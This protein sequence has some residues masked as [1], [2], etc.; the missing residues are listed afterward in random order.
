MK[1]AS[2]RHR[3]ASNP[4]VYNRISHQANYARLKMTRKEEHNSSREGLLRTHSLPLRPSLEDAYR[5]SVDSDDRL[6]SLDLNAEE[7]A[8]LTRRGKWSWIPTQ[9]PWSSGYT[10]QDSTNK[11]QPASRRIKE[12]RGW[13]W[14]RKTCLIVTLIVSLGLMTVVASGAL[15]VWTTAPADGVS[16]SGPQVENAADMVS[17]GI[18][19]VVPDALGRHGLIMG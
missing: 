19:P 3:R 12:R 5:S 4:H 16:H 7:K 8:R 2:F 17:V 6:D 18:A 1:S 11:K 10:Y 13:L 14:Q 9:P 15:W